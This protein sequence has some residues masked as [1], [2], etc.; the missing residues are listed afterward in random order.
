MLIE[1]IWSIVG[2]IWLLKVNMN[3]CAK[4]VYFSVLANIIFFSVTVVLL[5]IF[6]LFL[7]DPISHL[8]QDNI[9]LKRSKLF[10]YLR[11][12]FCCCFMFS[13][14]SRDQNYENSFQQITSLLEMVFRGGDLTPTDI[15]AGIL[16]L[17][18]REK[19]QYVR[20]SMNNSHVHSS[21]IS[22]EIKLHKTAWMNVNEASH[23]VEY[24][25]S[26]YTWSYF[27]YMNSVR[28]CC[29]LCCSVNALCCCCLA[30][31]C[32]RHKRNIANTIDGDNMC[33]W[34]LKTFKKLSKVEDCDIIYANFR[35]ELF[36]APFV[37]LLDHHKKTVV[38]AIRGTLSLR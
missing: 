5:I 16:L 23:Y 19:H 11:L 25:C 32:V 38:I 12:L 7:F 26:T 31:C 6:L 17:S 34:H 13:G 18:K 30:T 2:L 1:S 28:G 35:N 10:G 20:E 3:N 37:I 9:E 27:I 24:A 22:E 14:N 8:E 33:N 4:V 36:H 21:R 15:T 29:E